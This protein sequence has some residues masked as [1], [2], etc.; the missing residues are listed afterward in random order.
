M[1]INKRLTLFVLLILIFLIAL[2][3]IL[4]KIKINDYLS[5]NVKISAYFKNK[6]IQLEDVFELT[7][8]GNVRAIQF[9][10]EAA[11]HIGNGLVGV[12]NLLNPRLII[13]GGGIS[14]SYKFMIKTINS[15]VKRRAMKV[16]GDMVR[17]VRA[18]LGDNAG[19]LG[20]YV[21]VKAALGKRI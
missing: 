4:N 14:N 20:S 11:V 15:I 21:L 17:I 16:Q 6:N 19:I 9:W 2:F 5:N 13:I 1:N 8:C 3:L 18:K 7:N 12:I 10:E